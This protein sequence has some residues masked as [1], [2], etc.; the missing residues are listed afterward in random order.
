[1]WPSWTARKAKIVDSEPPC[2]RIST[3][4]SWQ[5]WALLKRGYLS[6]L[7]ANTERSVVFCQQ[8]GLTTIGK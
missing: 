6:T 3:V 5:T 1:M 8:F 2:V 7:V 4:G